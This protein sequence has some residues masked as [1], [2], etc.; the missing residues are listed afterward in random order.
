MKDLKPARS[1]MPLT[2]FWPKGVGSLLASGLLCCPVLADE[3]DQDPSF[4]IGGLIFGDLY[5]IPSHHLPE[6]D[7]AAGAVIRRGY[8]TMDADFTERTFGRLRFELNQS[9]EFET[10]T[11]SARVKDLYLGWK[12][13]RHRLVAGLSG[14]P[15]FDLIESIWGLRYLAR[16]PMDLQGAPSRDTGLSLQGPL[17]A[18][19]TLSYRVM[20]GSKPRF[21]DDY[22]ETTK[23]MG[24]LTWKPGPRWTLDL[25][26]DYAREHGEKVSDTL[27]AFAAWQSDSLRWGVQ[28]SNQQFKVGRPIELASGF[29]IG[30]LAPKISLVGRVDRLLEPSREGNSIAYLPM[31]PTARA[32][33]FFGGVEYR[34]NPLVSLTPNVVVTAY[35]RNG[36]GVRPESDVYLR[37][38]VFANFE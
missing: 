14:T 34:I 9:G 23:W 35:D 16:T 4:S 21:E 7:S 24:A 1:R 12:I 36:A 18:A 2:G 38:T 32:T 26:A 15:T 20:Y 17:N 25:Y 3:T 22:S 6:G 37:F 27:Q 11:F 19:E 29:V 13:G 8:L 28:Y 30:G 5:A 31:D 10:Y 33:T